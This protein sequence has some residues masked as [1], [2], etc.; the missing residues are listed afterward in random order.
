MPIQRKPENDNER[1]I[2]AKLQ[3]ISMTDEELWELAKLTSSPSLRSIEPVYK[4][5][6]QATEEHRAAASE[7]VNDLKRPIPDKE[8]G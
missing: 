6:K 2:E 4:W 7:W 1:P 5:I 3:V 8:E